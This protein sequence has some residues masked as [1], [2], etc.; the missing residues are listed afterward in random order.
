M[1]GVGRWSH[2]KITCSFAAKMGYC[3]GPHE[4]GA[5]AMRAKS[6]KPLTCQY[7]TRLGCKCQLRAVYLCDGI[8]HGDHTDEFVG[9]PVS[10]KGYAICGRHFALLEEDD[11]FGCASEDTMMDHAD[12]LLF[13]IP[14][15]LRFQ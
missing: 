10:E 7:R 6:V 8:G 15:N 11:F 9:S 13:N 3:F 5:V 4:T 1:S 12:L 2:A 14:K